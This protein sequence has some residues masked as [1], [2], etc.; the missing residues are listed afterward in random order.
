MIYAGV[1]YRVSGVLDCDLRAA[2]RPPVPS[3]DRL[4]DSSVVWGEFGLNFADASVKVVFFN[5]ALRPQAH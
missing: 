3:H 4:T 5:C 1:V 2:A